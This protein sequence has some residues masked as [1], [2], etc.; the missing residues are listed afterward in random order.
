MALVV[1]GITAVK[2]IKFKLLNMF[3]HSFQIRVRYAETDQM[4]FVH[5]SNY[6]QY[7]EA[8]RWEAMRELGICYKGMEDSG[9]LMPV[10]AMN[11]EFI[12]PAFYDELL[13]VKTIITDLPKARMKFEYELYNEKTELISKATTTL[14]FIKKVTHK[15]CPPPDCLISALNNSFIQKDKMHYEP[16]YF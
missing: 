9:I 15:P 12:K 5:H 14:A 6:V 4:G 1:W 10:I 7:Y 2:I 11:Y 3:E 13:T 8:A 16:Q